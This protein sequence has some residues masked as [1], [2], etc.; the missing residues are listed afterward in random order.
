MSLSADREVLLGLRSMPATGGLLPI[1][2]HAATGAKRQF[3][4]FAPSPRN[5]EDR[6]RDTD[7]MST[8]LARLKRRRSGAAIVFR[9]LG[10][11]R[12]SD[13]VGVITKRT[14]A[15]TVIDNFET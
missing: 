10:R 2:R 5:G 11:P 12:A 3:L 14:I 8:T 1:S 9:G 4:T 6:S 7:L 15:D 13:V